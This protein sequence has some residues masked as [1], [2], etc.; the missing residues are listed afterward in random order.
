MTLTM[1]DHVVLED[2]P[3]TLLTQGGGG[4]VRTPDHVNELVPLAEVERKY[5]RRV[6]ALVD[7]NKSRA[8]EVLGL[9]RRTLYRKLKRYEKRR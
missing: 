1:F 9:D 2:L 3:E 8:A 6:L 7:G 5:I 4:P